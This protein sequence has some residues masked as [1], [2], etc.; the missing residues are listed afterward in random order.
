MGDNYQNKLFYF[1]NSIEKDLKDKKI[2]EKQF[3]FLLGFFLKTE[4]NNFVKSEIEEFIPQKDNFKE[5]TF[6]TYKRN[7]KFNYAN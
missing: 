6:I 5:M 3:S 1:I 7:R 4:L 2:D